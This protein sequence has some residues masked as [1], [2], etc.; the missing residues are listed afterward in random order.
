M[1]MVIVIMSFSGADGAVVKRRKNQIS[2]AAGGRTG[3][4]PAAFI[5]LLQGQNFGKLIVRVGPD[6]LALSMH[7]F[8]SRVADRSGYLFGRVMSADKYLITSVDNKSRLPH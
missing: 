1:T 3:N 4:A 6:D 7:Y 2:R 8:S 5:G